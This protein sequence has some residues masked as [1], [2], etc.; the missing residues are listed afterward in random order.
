M[1]ALELTLEVEAEI[2]ALHREFRSWFRGESNDISR[3]DGSFAA[4]F[5]FIS[6]QGEMVDRAELM[7][8]LRAGKGASRID[9]QIDNVMVHWSEG[10]AI[11]ASYEEIHVHA[12]YKTVRQSTVLMTRDAKAPGGFLWRH[13]HE[14]WKI[15]PPHRR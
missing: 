8:N 10:D 14:T 15:P 11:V 2:K 12:D 3:M 1:N 4:Y 9:I 13:V 5:T 7:Q 6:P